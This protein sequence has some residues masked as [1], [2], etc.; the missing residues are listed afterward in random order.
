MRYSR[1]FSNIES[2]VGAGRSGGSYDTT[3]YLTM[4]VKDCIN[5]ALSFCKVSQE[6][7]DQFPAAISEASATFHN[8]SFAGKAIT[9][10]TK[11]IRTLKIQ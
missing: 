8:D 10:A 4:W 2:I 7:R 1:Y 5:S 11:E 6:V 9:N 3:R